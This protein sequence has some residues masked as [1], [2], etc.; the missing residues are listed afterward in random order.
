MHSYFVHR[1]ACLLSPELSP[2]KAVEQA[3]AILRKAKSVRGGEGVYKNAKLAASIPG[4]LSVSERFER[5]A[6][7]RKEASLCIPT[8]STIMSGAPEQFTPEHN[9]EMAKFNA[10]DFTNGMETRTF[11]KL[12]LPKK[13]THADR[14]KFYRHFINDTNDWVINPFLKEPVIRNADHIR[15]PETMSGTPREILAKAATFMLWLP[16]HEQRVRTERS[17]KAN[18]V[19]W[20]DTSEGNTEG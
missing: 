9:A 4:D 5:F 19:R 10:T 12:L 18:K 6:A 11:L 16:I 15:V 1:I 8:P 20:D 13:K 2:E 14:L 3:L 7:I 17:L